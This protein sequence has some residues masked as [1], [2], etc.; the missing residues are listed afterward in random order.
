[1][2]GFTARLGRASALEAMIAH[3]SDKTMH[4]LDEYFSF[5]TVIA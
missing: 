4:N 2:N 5:I 3:R 1:M